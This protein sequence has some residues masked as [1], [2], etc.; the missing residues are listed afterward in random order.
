M[1]HSFLPLVHAL[2]AELDGASIAYAFT[3]PSSLALQGVAV[4]RLACLQLSV[5][6]DL[7][8]TA[9]SL[10]APY[11]PTPVETKP[12][13]AAF[14]FERDGLNVTVS[15]FYNVQVE[16]DP[17]R[18]PAEHDG[19]T[20]WAK[21]L[22]AYRR[23]AAPGDPYLERIR[24]HLMAI[25]R[26]GATVSAAAWS[27]QAYEAWVSR[28]GTPAEAAERI[29]RDP[30]A[31]LQPLRRHLGEVEGKR[32]VNLL[33]SH[34]S[35]AVALA[36]LGARATVVDISPENARYAT[37]LAQ[38]AGAEIRY[39]VSDV[40]A[41]DLTRLRERFDLALMEL[42]VLHYFVDLEPL[43]ET[44]A[45]LLRPGGRFVL[46]DFHP[47]ST[48]L[49]S[50]RGKKHK[51][52]GNYFDQSLHESEVA[53]T[54]YVHGEGAVP[55]RKVRHRRWTLGEVVTALAA[56]GLYI[57]TLEEEPN[58][59]LDDIGPPPSPARGRGRDNKPIAGNARGDE[60]HFKGKLRRGDHLLTSAVPR[61]T[62]SRPSRVATK[63]GQRPRLLR[64]GR[65]PHQHGAKAGHGAAHPGVGRTGV[66]RPQELLHS[67]EHR[68]PLLAAGQVG[69]RRHRHG[70]RRLLIGGGRHPQL[71]GDHQGRLRQ[72]QR[73]VLRMGGDGQHAVAP[74]QRLVWQPV[75]LPAEQDRHLPLSGQFAGLKQERCS[76]PGCENLPF[77]LPRP[78]GGAQ[79][80]GA[81]RQCFF[82]PIE[83][84]C[85]SHKPL[86]AM[87]DPFNA[88]R[89]ERRR[90]YQPQLGQTEVGHHADHGGDV[91]DILRLIQ[92]HYDLI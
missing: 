78:A 51:V 75:L 87:G 17:D 54:K 16:A 81:V 63:V 35:K 37:D 89:V 40:L 13:T 19:R 20:V 66:E 43:A 23:E 68:L 22:S 25:H 27:H 76:L 58:T 56:Q 10:F 77:R 83:P 41:L 38:A 39:I 30:G 61:S 73:A 48:K 46:Q 12:G 26:E 1:Q 69:H 71:V 92:D 21:S 64:T 59:K 72:V 52:T 67:A 86:R 91:D 57:R 84:A 88:I 80:K 90:L 5:Q 7:F 24:D 74:I 65:R 42:G 8:E 33:G 28:Y 55:P 2:A 34:G 36:L 70:H 44:V 9:R 62:R 45:A 15:C 3:G 50:S 11:A 31:R 82:E 60:N 49:I 14:R 79:N 47:V 18:V 32:V 6:W 53:F 4:D 29:R 85:G